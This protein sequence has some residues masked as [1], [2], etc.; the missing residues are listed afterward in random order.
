MVRLKLIKNFLIDIFMKNR[1]LR[2]YKLVNKFF[3]PLLDKNEMLFV[4]NNEK[5]H[6][7]DTKKKYSKTVFVETEMNFIYMRMI[8]EVIKNNPN[9]LFIG[10]YPN[11][12]FF[13][14]KEF[15][16]IVPFIYRL[17]DYKRAYNRNKKLYNSIGVSKVYKIE[18]LSLIRRFKNLLYAFKCLVNIK[19]NDSL[20]KLKI[21]NI[22]VGD[23]IYDSYLR[24]HNTPTFK[25]KSYLAFIFYLTR[26]LNNFNLIENINKE[27]SFD[28]AFAIYASYVSHGSIVRWFSNNNIENFTSAT[29]QKLFKKQHKDFP[30]ENLDHRMYR[31]DFLKLKNKNILIE[32]GLTSLQKRF[33]GLPDLNFMYKSAYKNS[34]IQ[35]NKK[36]DGVVFLHDFFDCVH[37][38]RNM[39]FDD[40]YHWIIYLFE[41]ISDNNLNIGIKPHPLQIID[42]DNVCSDLKKRYP[43]INWI[44]SEISNTEIFKSGIKFGLSVYGTVLSELAYHN[45]IPISCGDNPTS[46][47]SFTFEAKSIKEYKKLIIHHKNLK[48]PKDYLEQVG[49]FYFMHYINNSSDVDIEISNDILKKRYI[50]HDSSVLHL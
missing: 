34:N 41:L 8:H 4:K 30:F 36:Y 37:L 20:F 46:S 6:E 33:E 13:K 14:L 19:S 45:I 27:F 44:D 2:Y 23:I 50:D 31:K 39:L 3:N 22:I 35:F 18:D 32:K 16:L 38:Y 48:M 24:F 49:Q 12:F 42:S 11:K 10:F 29:D 21:S 7:L 5:H 40:F 47:F 26:L 28:S 1:L 9:V 25:N 15:I 17:L 43:N